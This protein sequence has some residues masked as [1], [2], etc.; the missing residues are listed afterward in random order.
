MISYPMVPF[1]L[2]GTQACLTWLQVFQIL[3]SGLFEPSQSLP[4]DTQRVYIQ[5]LAMA[6]A[7]VESR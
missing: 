1:V 2:N 4:E 6:A 5:L 3:T 7:A